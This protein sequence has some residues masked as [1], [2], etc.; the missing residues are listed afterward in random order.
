M[1]DDTQQE[2]AAKHGGHDIL[3][4]ATSG[5]NRLWMWSYFIDGRNHSVGRVPCTSAQ[6]A[7]RQGLNAAK[8]RVDGMA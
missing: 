1:A 5:P 7:L 6:V 2:L 8:A 4:R 3:V